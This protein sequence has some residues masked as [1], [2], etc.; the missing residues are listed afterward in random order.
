MFEF[1]GISELK[2]V[3]KFETNEIPINELKFY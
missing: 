2:E 3:C 1:D